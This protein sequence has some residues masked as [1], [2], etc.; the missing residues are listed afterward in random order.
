[1]IFL[2]KYQRSSG[3]VDVQKYATSE[4]QLAEGKRLEFEIENLGDDNLDYEILLFEA[5]TEEAF[6]ITHSRYFKTAQEIADS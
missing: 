3:K 2:V 6:R 1:M 5:E 4:R